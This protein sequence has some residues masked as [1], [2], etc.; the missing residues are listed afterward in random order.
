M[1]TS[2][3]INS[4]LD[5][6]Y[7]QAILAQK[8]AAD[9]QYTRLV[10]A[11]AGSGKT[12]VLVNR[13]SRILLTGTPP[14]KILCLTYTKAAAAEM[15]SR[16]FET[17]GGWSILEAHELTQALSVLLGSDQ[18][19]PPL[20]TARALFAKALETPDGLKVQTIHAFC[21]RILARFPLEAGILP[22]FE[23]IDDGDMRIIQA[24]V[25]KAL[26]Q[27]AAQNPTDD[28][29]HAVQF[30]ATQK[31]D[32]T[33]DNLF[34]WMAGASDKITTWVQSGG[35]KNL[36]QILD[37]PEN[38]LPVSDIKTQ[39]WQESPKAEVR[40][41]MQGL[42]ASSKPKEIKYGELLS[43][44]LAEED[45][46]RA[47][48][49][50]AQVILKADLT[51]FSQ[52]GAKSG[53]AAATALF[54]AY[55]KIDTPENNRM[56]SVGEQLKAAVCL[57][58]TRAVYTL[59]Q[60]YNRYFTQIKHMR[61][62]LD[63]NDQI[64]LVRS[65]LMRS[66]VSD[67]VRYKLDGGVNHILVDEAQDTAPAQWDIIEAL[68]E[69]FFQDLPDRDDVRTLFAVGDEKQSIY[70]FQGARPEQFL[71]KIQNYAGTTRTGEI[72]M[73]MSFRSA[74]EVL[75]FVDQVCVDDRLMQRMFGVQNYAPASDILRHIAF[76]KDHGQVDFWPLA[77]RPETLDDK[78]AWDTSP[79]DAISAVDSRETL[80]LEISLQI[81]SWIENQDPIYDRTL[82][83]MRPIRPD[84][85]LVLVL[86]RNAF[87]EA[88][89]RN[90]KTA[91]VA[92]AGA[93]RLKLKQS[94]AVKDLLA[95][96]RFVLLPSD[97]LS[98]AEVLKSP[99]MGCD[100]D[101]LYQIAYDRPAD[102]ATDSKEG[103]SQSLWST[104]KTRRPELFTTLETMIQYSRQFAPYEFF[105]RVLA[106]TDS[107]GQ[108]V[109]RKFYLRLGLEAKEAIEAFL[110]K[111]LLHQRQNAPSLQNFVQNFVNDDQILK[112]EMDKARGQVRVMT[113]HGAKGLE[114][115]IVIL[116]DTT[117]TPRSK[118]QMTPLDDGF[119]L[120]GRARDI[121][122][123]LSPY[124]EM[125]T[126]RREEEYYRL[127]Y[128]AMTRAEQRLVICGY[129]HGGARTGY[130]KESWYEVCQTAMQGLD[131]TPFETPFGNGVSFGTSA[132]VLTSAPPEVEKDT[133]EIPSWLY[134]PAR[135]ERLPY[136]RVTPS[137]LLAAPDSYGS[138][139]RS[140]LILAALKNAG[141]DKFQR[142]NLI[143][144]LLELLPDI[145]PAR[146]HDVSRKYLDLNG[147]ETDFA[148]EIMSEVFS[149]LDHAEFQLFFGEGSRAEVSLGGR[150]KTL[151]KGLYLNGQIDRLT[152][153]DT[154]VY[155]IDYKSN[156]PSPQKQA[157]VPD[158]YMAQMAAY[159]EL[160]KDIYPGHD[161]VC[162]LLWTD[163]PFL[164]T[165]DTEGLDQALTR[166]R[167]LLT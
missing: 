66:E 14:E 90:L 145:A 141:R 142:G 111:A 54:G 31:A 8:M 104:L 118:N 157:D 161:I 164:M 127:L 102:S 22:G 68:S 62:G 139:I 34:A 59:A 64:S 158:M 149:V 155:I 13:I 119:V 51:P 19:L 110:D 61:R 132:P 112:R 5:S 85:V 165:L 77:P 151:P 33:L 28:L 80:A 45:P 23:P 129:A 86:Q 116:P 133:H 35:I 98:L 11:N 75:R 76:R 78:A 40:A 17:L 113:V 87:F 101:A 50:Y 18:N 91:G 9:P 93:D 162:A 144:K 108:S 138:D 20:R 147:V 121:P 107:A 4:E 69:P 82:A 12:H 16:L 6:D 115:P 163:E 3:D 96:A 83:R 60:A 15:Q 32:Q 42:L 92:V 105:A 26:L 29:H 52:I 7:R 160:A 89:I 100:E 137:H 10:S 143:H 30:L 39:A 156:R 63:F 53:G 97:D 114:A 125:Q 136:R 84:D 70:S 1:K 106:M 95:L 128:V 99:L 37:L 88:I 56:A 148:T 122:Q 25:R 131:T 117:Q 2:G 67:W 38:G 154:H 146:R 94:I 36:A 72:R 79:V 134:T 130:T 65:L 55:N 109:L 49:Y 57:R 24:Q 71:N 126:Q 167:A 159:R 47:F 43:F 123:S 41:A 44:A 166:V 140:P 81:K 120:A 150:A 103:T 73:R 153:T 46:V 58:G 152:V 74:P 27:E 124:I 48:D 135:S 21:E